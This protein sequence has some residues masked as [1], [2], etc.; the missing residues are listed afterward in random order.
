MARHPSLRRWALLGILLLGASPAVAQ[1]PDSGVFA[2]SV[3]LFRGVEAEFGDVVVEED[4]AGGLH[5]T[6][7]LDPAVAGPRASVHQVL[8][9]MSMAGLPEGLSVVPDDPDAMRMSVRPQRGAWASAGAEFGAV[10]SMKPHDDC[11]GHRHARHH[12]HGRHGHSGPVQAVGFTLM[13]DQPLSLDDV[14]GMTATRRG[15]VTQIGV[16]AL[17]ADVGRHHPAEV[18][19]LG[20]LF[21]PDA[22]AE[23]DGE[24]DGGSPDNGEDGGVTIPPGCFGVL[25]PVTGAVVD[26]I[27][28]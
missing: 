28:F 21:A 8:V 3:E 26:V 14:L 1:E 11:R 15:V 12:R 7:S 9:S 20:G 18:A 19:L 22:P 2:L 5:M 25:D 27:C 16:M 13:A 24:D 17:R 6:V 4:G 23:S 10:V